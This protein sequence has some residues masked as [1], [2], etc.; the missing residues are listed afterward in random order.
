M[1]PRVL[2]ITPSLSKGGAETQLLKVARF[3]NSRQYQV[4]IISLKPIKEFNIDLDKEGIK[5]LM[6]DNWTGGAMMN[7][8]RL[9]RAVRDF[10]ADVVVAFM[11]IAIIFS[12][13]LKLFFSFR[14]ISTIRISVINRK[15]FIP[16]KVTS[17]LD[18][19][20]VYN[21]KASKQNFE[22]NKLVSKPGLVI[23]NGITIPTLKPLEPENHFKPFVWTCIGHFRWNKDYHTLFRAI[24][25]LKDKNFRVDILG[26]L[27]N[28]IWPFK[29]IEELG[30]V[31]N[32]RIMGFKPNA[33]E[34]LED[35]DAFVLSSFSEGMPNAILE[36]MAYCKPIVATD[37][38]GNHEVITDAGCGYLTEVANAEDLAEKM[39]TMMKLTDA[40]RYA[41]GHAGRKFIEA[42]FS[43]EKVL[44]DWL[45]V[46]NQQSD[47]RRSSS[48]ESGVL[49]PHT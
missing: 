47:N 46:I 4:M 45:N 19:S 12:R 11:F 41:L 39:L 20:I 16:F 28:E 40:G 22:E 43:E 17:L 48:Q 42:N 36:A 7:M 3:L 32:V 1:N 35:A 49:I 37:I 25:I 34:Y 27:N 26:G 10:R 33:S 23:Y 8:V 44:K 31:D 5:L 2:F 15:W 30:I 29:M 18:D 38:D 9:F 14:L 21:S 6:L 24:A 13:L